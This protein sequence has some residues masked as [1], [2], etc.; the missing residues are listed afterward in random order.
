MPLSPEQSAAVQR[1]GQ[2]VCCV[3]GPGSGKTRVLVERF[4][5]QVEQGV[6][7]ERILAITFTEK[8]ATEIK[9]RL[10]SHFAA[11]PDL[12]EAIERAQVSTVH[13]F[14]AGL[15]R[16][17]AL[18]AGLDPAFRV[19]DELEA[20]TLRSEAM[21]AVLDRWATEGTAEYR[22][23]IEAW[24]CFDPRRHLLAVHEAIRVSGHGVSHLAEDSDFDEAAALAKLAA[25]AQQLVASA[26]RS[27]EN[28]RRKIEAVAQWLS[29]REKM[30][31]LAWVR[32]FA[33]NL[34]G[35]DKEAA[36]LGRRLRTA[37]E[38]ALGVLA[39]ALHAPQFETLR[40]LLTEYDSAYQ[41]RKDAVA[42]VD[43][44]DLEERTLTLLSASGPP[45]RDIIERFDAILMDELQDTNPLQW[46]ILDR[47]RRPARFFAVGDL[48]QSIYGFRHADPG[49][50]QQYQH[51]LE[52]QGGA[53]DRLE[54]NYRSR[55]EILAAASAVSARAEGVRPHVL[56][57]R[58]T[59]HPPKASA[60]VEILRFE[61]GG[62]DADVDEVESEA[63]WVAWRLEQL[64]QDLM[65]GGPPRPVR[66]GD[67]AVLARASTRFAEL[68]AAF[69]ARGI[70]FQVRR[71][72]NF[73][74]E[75]EVLDLTN[76]LRYL[77]NPADE[78][79]LYALLRSTFFVVSD[80]SL[81]AARQRGQ[82]P[83]QPAADILRS[84]IA[85]RE[86]L[87]P[88]RLI[89]RFVDKR[90]YLQSQSGQAQANVHKF[91]ALLRGF[92][93]RRPGVWREWLHEMELLR[94]AGDE[95]NAPALDH[96][97]A[98]EIM[99]IHQSKGLEFPVVAIVNL[100][101]P[102]RGET[103]PLAWASGFGLGAAWRLS[104]DPASRADARL[105]A[106][107][108]FR[109]EREELESHRL[110]YV[111]MTRAAEHLL[112]S[113]TKNQR[114]GSSW[115]RLVG[116]GLQPDWPET[117][118]E[119]R[120]THGVR[121]LRVTG[122][123]PDAAPPAQAHAVGGAREV[124]RAEA[125][126]EHDAAVGITTL[127]H[128]AECPRRY[129][130]GSAA[131]WP[132][133]LDSG[134]STGARE[135]GDEVH[136]LLAGLPVATPSPEAEALRDGFLSS[137]LGGMMKRAHRVEREFDFVLAFEGVLL[138]GVI[139]LWFEGEEGLTLVDYKTGREIP[140]HTLQA[141]ADQ[142]GFYALALEKL[143]GRLPNRAALFLLHQDRVVETP[144]NGTTR[145]RC[146]RILQHWMRADADQNW[147]LRAGAHCQWCSW[148]GGACPGRATLSLP[149]NPS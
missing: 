81:F 139:D 49:L 39:G 53:V 102:A 127:V 122:T 8:A 52:Q 111:A 65:V 141:Y 128:F 110:L 27:T 80:Q 101:R 42:A 28:R 130:F 62:S 60:S 120:T 143:L 135:L 100:Q 137:P 74:D 145:E 5:W 76:L 134:V 11:R 29:S 103:E 25:E 118:G 132:R 88:D 126:D 117:T 99:S 3:A 98:V 51:D 37:Q 23:L 85:D 82:Y 68:E 138:R 119:S 131:G 61:P 33:I 34:T 66:W 115:V 91:L 2:D 79:A 97:D 46:R 73:F 95:P 69:A 26:S 104:G 10:A 146:L 16:E 92:N 83:P 96:E 47:L 121:V 43:F 67:M 14:C 31:A 44:H 15:L 55:P 17:R 123:P 144:I 58:P 147:P 140:A 18:E 78:I 36:T 89:G 30:P 9:Q 38:E 90:G 84:L 41:M 48:N 20:E 114:S 59:A 35:L 21:D 108:V 45:R 71:G 129:Y 116:E 112:L 4:A 87:P 64:K 50:F 19:L 13:S 1:T 24:A 124:R 63:A 113:W 107:R 72:R 109:K 105:A 149:G 142:L 22:A 136:R 77:A 6:S 148:E 70:P 133:P 12:R 32:S 94:A 40:H 75:Q 57:A 7:P 125:P 86:A 106:I 56:A 93:E 54:T